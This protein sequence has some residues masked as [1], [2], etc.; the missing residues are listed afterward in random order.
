[1]RPLQLNTENG[2]QMWGLLYCNA[3]R[4]MFTTIAKAISKTS[5]QANTELQRHYQENKEKLID[6]EFAVNVES[7]TV[8]QLEIIKFKFICNFVYLFS[9]W[10]N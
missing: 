10:V 9:V 3:N 5:Y 2:I 4:P 8:W 1:M 6:D 7:T